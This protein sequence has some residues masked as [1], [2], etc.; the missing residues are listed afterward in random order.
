MPVVVWSLRLRERYTERSD[1]QE[2]NEEDVALHGR[3]NGLKIETKAQSLRGR[4]FAFEVVVMR[5]VG[6]PTD[7]L[8]RWHGTKRVYEGIH[9]GKHKV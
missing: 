1:P 5:H 4:V 3:S 9:L 8:A 7:D 2:E 6:G